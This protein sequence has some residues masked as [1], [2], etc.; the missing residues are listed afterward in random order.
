M[1]DWIQIGDVQSRCLW[2]SHCKIAIDMGDG[3]ALA[4]GCLAKNSGNLLR[5]RSSAGVSFSAWD[6]LCLNCELMVRLKEKLASK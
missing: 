6:V 3:L 5:E 2:S 4:V 1:N